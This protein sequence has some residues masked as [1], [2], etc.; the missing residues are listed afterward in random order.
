MAAGPP[1]PSP[2]LLPAT[3]DT[4]AAGPLRDALLARRG[5]PLALDGGE[6]GRLGGLCLEVLLSARRRWAA[7]GLPFALRGASDPLR[8]ALALFGAAELLGDAA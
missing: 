8:E 6:V 4:R 3:L 1:Y 7:D 5:E 2:F